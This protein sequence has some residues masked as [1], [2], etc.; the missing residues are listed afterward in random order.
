M[1]PGLDW[2]TQLI[3]EEA[4]GLGWWGRTK[5][6]MAAWAARKLGRRELLIKMLLV[7]SALRS[8]RAWG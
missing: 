3:A 5:V 1:E 2:L 6:S 4:N 7:Q 8:H